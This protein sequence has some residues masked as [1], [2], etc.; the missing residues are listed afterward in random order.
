[1]LHTWILERAYRQGCAR[2]RAGGLGEASGT[3]IDDIAV[4]VRNIFLP[5]TPHARVDKSGLL[6]A[7]RS[8]EWNG[9]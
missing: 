3:I 9:G 1:M 2:R 8:S 5:H 7:H 4:G 6:P